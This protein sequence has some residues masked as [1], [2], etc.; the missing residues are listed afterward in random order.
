MSWLGGLK[1]EFHTIG[2][3]KEWEQVFFFFFLLIEDESERKF[4][5][6]ERTWT[7]A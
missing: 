7:A 5:G 4:F 1:W 2:I 6:R 3:Q